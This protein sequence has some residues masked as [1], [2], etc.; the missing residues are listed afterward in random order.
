MAEIPEVVVADVDLIK[1]GC[2]KLGLTFNRNKCELIENILRQFVHLRPLT[3]TLLG[4]LPLSSKEALT[5]TL[6]IC[7]IDLGIVLDKLLHI[8]RLDA[9][10]IRCSLLLPMLMHML[11]ST[12]CHGHPRRR[13]VMNCCERASNG[14]WT[15]R[16]PMNGGHRPLSRLGWEDW[17]YRFGGPRYGMRLFEIYMASTHRGLWPIGHA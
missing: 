4:V 7:T 14:F 10:L 15:C 8:A 16:W 5:S 17:G 6:D 9:L 13:S 12:S 3:A 2:S 11:R 1:K